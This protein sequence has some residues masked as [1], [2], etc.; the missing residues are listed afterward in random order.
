M[1]RGVLEHVEACAFLEAKVQACRESG[2]AALSGAAQF[3]LK[4]LIR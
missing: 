2:L 3:E 4:A 1:G